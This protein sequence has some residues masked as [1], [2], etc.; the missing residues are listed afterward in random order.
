MSFF[1]GLLQKKRIIRCQHCQQQL[2][3]PIKAKSALKVTCPKC[4]AT[5]TVKFVNPLSELVKWDKKKTVKQNS[6]EKIPKKRTVK[7]SEVVEQEIETQ[8]KVE[9]E[10][11]ENKPESSE[12]DTKVRTK[13]RKPVRRKSSKNDLPINE[14]LMQENLLDDFTKE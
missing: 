8:S 10:S 12:V 1:K 7:K 4:R 5:F 6:E 11:P 13:R 14:E 2:R 3:I 9:E